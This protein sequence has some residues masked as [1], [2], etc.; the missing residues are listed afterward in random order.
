MTQ[1]LRFEGKVAIVTG[2]A[3]G[4]GRAVVGRFLQ[5][6]GSVAFSDL[7]A[8]GKE[9]ALQ[10]DPSGKRV[11]FVQGDM[12]EEAFCSR[13][14]TQTFNHFGRIDFLVNNAFAFI[15]R[16]LDARTEDWNRSYFVG[17][18]GF[19][20]MIQAVAPVM[21]KSGGGAVVNVGS[22]SGHIAQSNRWT[23][24]MSKGAVNQLTKC[25]ALD[26]ACDGIR[27]NSV[28]PGWIWSDEVLN[29]A[30]SAGGKDKWA[31]VWGQYHML[32]RCGEV[33]EVA[34]PILF[35]LSDDASFITGTD[36]AVDGGYLSMGPEGHGDT[37]VV[38]GAADGR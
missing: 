12:G 31:P 14:A 27:I 16:A 28:S 10:L 20:R 8:T 3:G 24:N 4:I 5:E 35:L 9:I 30:E 29:A 22:I 33:D 19:A 6:G 34:K 2:G 36:L 15:A 7:N 18:V 37:N 11:L 25:A 38:V 13:L 17:P 23:Y 32:R 1:Q 21:R 26:L